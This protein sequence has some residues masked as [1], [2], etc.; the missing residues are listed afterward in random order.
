MAMF[1]TAVPL[2]PAAAARAQAAAFAAR[3]VEPPAERSMLRQ[4]PRPR[5][6]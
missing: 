5:R 4:P 3:S 1:S 2:S 6:R